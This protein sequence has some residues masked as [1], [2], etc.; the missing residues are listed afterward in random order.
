[1]DF[2]G[3]AY[4]IN[5]INEN[6]KNKTINLGIY[7][8]T[9]YTCFMLFLPD[10]LLLFFINTRYLFPLELLINYVLIT[11]FVVWYILHHL[12]KENNSKLLM[13]TPV[14]SRFHFHFIYLVT[15]VRVF[16][17]PNKYLFYLPSYLWVI[18]KRN[19]KT[20]NNYEFFAWNTTCENNPTKITVWLFYDDNQQGHRLRNRLQA[21]IKT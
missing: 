7:H 15:N 5:K 18:C 14:L 6:Y 16:P 1:M 17:S 19:E 2:L 12:E 11:L 21:K 4:E 13:K 3:G 20:V 8:G 9:T 10:L